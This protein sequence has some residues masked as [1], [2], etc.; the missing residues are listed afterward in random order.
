MSVFFAT[1]TS[2]RS[3][4]GKPRTL[5]SAS[6]TS[7]IIGASGGVGA[8]LAYIIANRPR[9]MA[10]CSASQSSR[11]YVPL[12]MTIDSAV[13]PCMGRFVPERTSRARG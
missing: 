6:S 8:S 13:A 10:G 9:G 2:A 4:S 5:R 12:S 7:R 11:L 1:G 3:A